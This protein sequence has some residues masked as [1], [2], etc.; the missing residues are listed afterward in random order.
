MNRLTPHG[1]TALATAILILIFFV[2]CSPG[3]SPSTATPAPD[4]G[5]PQPAPITREGREGEWQKVLAEARKEGSVNVYNVWAPMA[6]AALEKGFKDRHGISLEFTSAGRAEELIAR[7]QAENRAGI[8]WADVF[9]MGGSPSLVIAKPLR[10]FQS[11]ESLLLLPEVT[12]AK[13]WHGQV[14]P[15]LDNEKQVVAMAGTAMRFVTYNTQLVKQG[16][17]ASYKDVLKPQY[18]GKV[19]LNDP[20]VTGAGLGLFGHLAYHIWS[21]QE[22]IDYLRQAIRNETTIMRDLRLQVEWLARGR[23]SISLA[24]TPKIFDEFL[25]AGSPVAPV[26]MKEGVYISTGSSTVS[27]AASPPHPNATA[28]FVN[29]LLSAEGQRA[30]YR[31]AAAASLRLDVPAAGLNSYLAPGP[32]EKIFMDS[33]DYIVKRGKLMEVGRKVIEETK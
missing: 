26:T 13:R 20:S 23:S 24:P 28:V 18:R 19:S 22:A 6:R 3:A 7:V 17:I 25:D 1:I 30:Y 32:D 5:Q 10:L 21:E 11:V 14:F 12:E 27:V 31:P 4:K 2:G 15:Y 16:E 29:W 33:E 9:A 8:Y